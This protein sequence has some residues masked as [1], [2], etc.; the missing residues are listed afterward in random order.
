MVR[1]RGGERDGEWV[2]DQVKW[3]GRGGGESDEGRGDEV[4][5]YNNVYTYIYT[6]V[7]WVHFIIIFV[8][9]CY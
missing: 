2:W 8:C 3:R 6:F 7:A 9:S 5:I 1:G 4:I